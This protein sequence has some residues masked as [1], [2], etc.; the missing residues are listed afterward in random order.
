MPERQTTSL[1]APLIALAI[2]GASACGGT[3]TTA[4]SGP[5]AIRCD[6]TLEGTTTLLPAN[7]SHAVVQVM[8]ARECEWS[9]ATTASWLQPN[10]RTGSG[11]SAVTLTAAANTSTAS[12]TA[13]LVVAAELW[14]VTQLGAEPISSAGL[15]ARS[16][17]L[18]NAPGR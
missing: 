9:A 3:E 17:L 5:S 15:S 2:L 6:V 1:I 13:T 18:S 10:P 11:S 7:A 8:A 14:T 16:T 12:R 4:L